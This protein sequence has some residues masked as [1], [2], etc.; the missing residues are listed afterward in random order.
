MFSPF[1]IHVE[2]PNFTR[3]Y[4]GRKTTVWFSYQKV[5]AFAVS[6]YATVK[7]DGKGETATTR[8]HLAK[9]PAK[10]VLSEQEFNARVIVLADSLDDETSRMIER[11]SWSQPAMLDGYAE[12]IASRNGWER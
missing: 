8:K 12:S 2:S 6:G 4:I 11:P 10:T 1:E 9:I 7:L 5:I 3:I